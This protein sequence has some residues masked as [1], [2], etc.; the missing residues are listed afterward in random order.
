MF[1]EIIETKQ[2]KKITIILTRGNVV[3]KQ[4]VEPPLMSKEKLEIPLRSRI[5]IRNWTKG[6]KELEYYSWYELTNSEC[7]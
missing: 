4:R 5:I 2:N 7:V 6:K 3:A 1:H